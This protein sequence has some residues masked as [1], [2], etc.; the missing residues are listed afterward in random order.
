MPAI[1]LVNAPNAPGNGDCKC[2]DVA[3]CQSTLPLHTG[4]S[5][6]ANASAADA[7]AMATAKRVTTLMPYRLSTVNASTISVAPT[8][9]GICGRYQEWMAVA[10]KMAVNPQVG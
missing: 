1:A 5:T 9:I 10:D 3:A 4:I 2:I 8:G 7:E 6:E